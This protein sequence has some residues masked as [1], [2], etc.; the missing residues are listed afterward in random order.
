MRGEDPYKPLGLLG[1]TGNPLC[2]AALV[3]CWFNERELQSVSQQ[4]LC[5]HSNM[6]YLVLLMFA[7]ASVYRVCDCR[8]F[9]RM[10][11]SHVTVNRCV[12]VV[13]AAFVIKL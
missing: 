10:L 7:S 6:T 13:V 11:R 8:R 4:Q 9:C 12:V 2:D 5:Y 1:V 3:M